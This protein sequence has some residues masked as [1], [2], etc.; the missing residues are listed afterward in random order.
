MAR[1]ACSKFPE[2]QWKIPRNFGCFLLSKTSKVSSKL[3]LV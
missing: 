1:F 2:K 3:S